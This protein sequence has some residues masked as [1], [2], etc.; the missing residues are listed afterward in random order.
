M[1]PPTQ[2]LQA[3]LRPTEPPTPTAEEWP[4]LALAG[5]TSISAPSQLPV[6]A[7]PSLSARAN[8]GFIRAL[9]FFVA[10]TLLLLLLPVVLVAALAIRIESPG[11]IFFRANRVGWRGRRL[12]MLKFRK[13]HE[14]ASGLALTTDD[15]HRFTRI[16]ALLARLKL[17]ELPQ[18]WHVLRGD[19]SLVGPRPEDPEFVAL[20]HNAYVTI[21]DVRPG[22]TGLSQIA[23]LEESRI[24]D[25]DDPLDHYLSSILPQK[26]ELDAMYARRRTCLMNLRIL[27]WT[28]AAVIM[29][30]QVAVHRDSG[31]MNF[32]KR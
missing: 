1:N 4:A 21:L 31:K 17:D 11:P 28:A 14:D 22:I 9:D 8:M 20:H 7:G 25:D 27:R 23:F 26:V 2:A 16:G 12:K 3:D 29:R 19:M 32:R 18:L 6:H 15:D 5:G 13:M 24:L 10:L 30:R